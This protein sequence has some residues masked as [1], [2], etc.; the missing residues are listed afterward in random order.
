MSDTIEAV[1]SGQISNA[2]ESFDIVLSG[3][4]NFPE[5]H[6]ELFSFT[7]VLRPGA[8]LTIVFGK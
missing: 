3:T 2:F 5:V 1:A 7:A 4:F 8:I 6:A